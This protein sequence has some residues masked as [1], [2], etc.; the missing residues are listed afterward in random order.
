MVLQREVKIPIWGWAESGEKVTVTFLGSKYQ[1]KTGKDSKWKLEFKAAP[2]GGPY[3]MIIQGKNT[4][5]LKNIVI[6]DV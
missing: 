1:T 3:E 2:A 6:G 4:I 5:S